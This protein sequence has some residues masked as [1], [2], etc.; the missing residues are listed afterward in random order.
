MDDAWRVAPSHSSRSGEHPH[1]AD[2][3]DRA[4]RGIRQALD[5][6]PMSQH[7][8]LYDGEPKAR[9]GFLRGKVRLEDFFPLVRG[10]ARGSVSVDTP[11]GE[12]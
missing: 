9:A 8:L 7:N 3:K 1:V 11:E 12:S 4:L 6:P 5:L 2:A 10:N